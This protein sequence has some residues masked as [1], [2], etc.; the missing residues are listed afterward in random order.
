ME[1]AGIIPGE[2]ARHSC[3]IVHLHC[4]LCYYYLITEYIS[5]FATV[6]FFAP[7]VSLSPCTLPSLQVGWMNLSVQQCHYQPA[8]T[9]MCLCVLGVTYRGCWH[10]LILREH[11]DAAFCFC[12]CFTSR[13]VFISTMVI[14][15]SSFCGPC[16]SL[17]GREL[18][19]HPLI[20]GAPETLCHS[21][22]FHRVNLLWML[23]EEKWPLGNCNKQNACKHRGGKQ[24][25][26]RW[27]GQSILLLHYRLGFS[28][29]AY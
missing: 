29:Y 15:F 3:K 19:G 22:H 6:H 1:R 16:V 13:L 24:Q 25:S 14:G 8:C 4:Q 18:E 7:I 20:Q 28:L 2:D 10:R 23:L 12:P 5:L 21:A 27:D 11:T 26:H 17:N 9:R